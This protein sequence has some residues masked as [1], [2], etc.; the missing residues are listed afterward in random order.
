MESLSF[1]KPQQSNLSVLLKNYLSENLG[2][3]DN[4]IIKSLIQRAEDF[5][6]EIIKS[7]PKH[8]FGSLHFNSHPAIQKSKHSYTG[9]SNEELNYLPSIIV[10][11]YDKKGNF[12][13]TKICTAPMIFEEPSAY[14]DECFWLLISNLSKNKWS[15]TEKRLD[16]IE[17]AVKELQSRDKERKRKAKEYAT[18]KENEPLKAESYDLK[19]KFF[20]GAKS[21]Y[22]V[23]FIPF[24]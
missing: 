11:E 24:E 3:K 9:Q 14:N 22:G 17:D 19:E 2:V 16:F 8:N 12:V 7:L 23:P 10:T 15:N 1:K 4:K 20:W 18:L 5:N 13:E 6:C 21:F